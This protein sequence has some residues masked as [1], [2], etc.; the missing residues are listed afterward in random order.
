MRLI[1]E[2]VAKEVERIKVDEGVD[3]EA[4]WRLG[5]VVGVGSLDAGGGDPSGGGPGPGGSLGVV[6][7][8]EKL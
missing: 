2:E 3:L 4:A 1:R 7:D 6:R 5:V 8:R